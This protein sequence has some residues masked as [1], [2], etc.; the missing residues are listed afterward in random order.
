MGSERTDYYHNALFG[1]RIA[2]GYIQGP[3]SYFLKVMAQ[4]NGADTQT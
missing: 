1:L 4:N 3:A 2:I